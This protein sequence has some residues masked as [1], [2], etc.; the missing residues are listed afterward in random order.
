MQD[1]Y[2]NNQIGG[3][4]MKVF[5]RGKA[6]TRSIEKEMEVA[7]VAAQAVDSMPPIEMVMN[8]F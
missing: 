5:K 2:A 6:P 8:L 1:K 3:F 4:M 7:K